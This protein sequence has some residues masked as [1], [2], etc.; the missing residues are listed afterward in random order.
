MQVRARGQRGDGW[1]AWAD[2]DGSTP[3]VATAAAKYAARGAA[4]AADLAKGS[5]DG[6]EG[7]DKVGV[8]NILMPSPSLA[9]ETA[10]DA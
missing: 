9:L 3:R 2:G 4:G 7:V 8:G 5:S 1:D 6:R 10:T